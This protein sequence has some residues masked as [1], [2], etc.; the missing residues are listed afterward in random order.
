M[1]LEKYLN[2]YKALILDIMERVNTDG[3]IGY[4]VEERQVILD[5]I[6]TMNFDRE[7][8][9]KISEILDLLNLEKELNLLILKE[10]KST[11]RKIE[12]IKKMHN[13]N[14]KYNAIGYVPSI[15]NKHS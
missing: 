2:E 13:A 4:L 5:K 12:N 9:R 3:S 15:F 10:K 14:M 6:V 1:E 8:I 11:K 7:S